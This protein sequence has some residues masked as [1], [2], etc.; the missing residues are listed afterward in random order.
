MRHDSV[1]YT[2]CIAAQH[3][4]TYK[5]AHAQQRAGAATQIRISVVHVASVVVVACVCAVCGQ[6]KCNLTEIADITNASRSR[7]DLRMR[8]LAYTRLLLGTAGRTNYASWIRQ[9]GAKYC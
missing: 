5:H 8:M 6:T 3:I 4:C 2:H 1:Y 9:G 7:R